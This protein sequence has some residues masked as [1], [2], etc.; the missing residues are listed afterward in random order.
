MNSFEDQKLGHITYVT[1]LFNS[2]AS[3]A[4]LKLSR[5]DH[6]TVESGNSKSMGM[7]EGPSH[8]VYLFVI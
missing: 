5:R 3:L 4:D 2:A 8:E 7:R 1:K 6:C